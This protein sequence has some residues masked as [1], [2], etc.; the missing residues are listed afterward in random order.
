MRTARQASSANE[1]RIAAR[2]CVE[3]RALQMEGLMVPT[4][5]NAG[6]GYL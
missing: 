6:G 3:M 2:G 4:V 5:A 1:R